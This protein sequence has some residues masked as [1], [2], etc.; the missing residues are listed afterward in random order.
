MSFSE[1]PSITVTGSGSTKIPGFGAIKISGYGSL[2]PE[3]ISIR[4]SSR[5]PGGLKVRDLK[6]SR[7]INFDGDITVD[8]AIVSGSIHVQGD[9]RCEELYK[10]GSLKVSNN[11]IAKFAKVKGSTKVRG[12]GLIEKMLDSRGSITFGDDLFSN[13]NIRCSG[14]IRVEGRVES[15][16]FEARLGRDESRIRD[17]IKADRIEVRR[18]NHYMRND[19]Y[20]VTTDIVGCDIVLENVICDNVEGNRVR[21]LRG[22][23]I[24]E[25][26]RFREQVS[27]DPNSKLNSEPEKI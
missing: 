24:K 21:I 2:A 15:K 26:T 4:G 11:L 6:S 12:K 9:L 3:E 8:S 22:C 16:S 14:S 25:K 17:G 10:S 5:I 23:H 27:V 18:D 1:I 19:V 7:S 20:L 13:G